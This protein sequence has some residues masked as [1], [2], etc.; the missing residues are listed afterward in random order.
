MILSFSEKSY[1]RISVLR[2]LK[3]Q[4]KTKIVP[5]NEQNTDVTSRNLTK[6]NFRISR[7][8]EYIVAQTNILHDK[9]SNFN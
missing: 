8:L 9:L 1:Y 4:L 6:I 5:V 7:V 2:N 3:W